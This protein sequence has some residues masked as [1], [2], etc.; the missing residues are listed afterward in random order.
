MPPSAAGT[1]VMAPLSVLVPE[2]VRPLVAEGA[3]PRARV[4]PDARVRLPPRV[5][6]PPRVALEETETAVA[7]REPVMS[8]L[9]PETVVAPVWVLLPERVRVPLP[10]LVRAVKEEA[11]PST[12][13][14]AKTESMPLAPTVKVA[15]A[16]GLALLL[17]KVEPAMPV[18]EP[19]E[20]ALP[21]TALRVRLPRLKSAEAEPVLPWRRKEPVPVSTKVPVKLESEPSRSNRVVASRVRVPVP[22]TAL[23]PWV[24]VALPPVMRES[25]VRAMELAGAKEPVAR[26]PPERVRVPLPRAVALPRTR[27]PAET[28]VPPV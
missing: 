20:R 9:P 23:M 6:W 22:E 5:P 13:E 16:D 11:E 7:P 14:P 21:E 27:V 8:R 3:T 26:V 2:T 10:V 4:E 19:R 17:P 15:V 24:P 28:V 1:T 18:S 12:T 25:A